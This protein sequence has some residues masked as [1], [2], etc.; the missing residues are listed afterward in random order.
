VQKRDL[1][2]GGPPL[3]VL[4]L[5]CNNFGRTTDADGAAEV[6]R[7]A[8]DEGITHFDTAEMYGEGRSEEFLGAAL[9]KHRHDVVIATKFTPRR[10]AEFRPGDL[11]ARIREAAEQS[12]R[13]LGTDWIDLYYQHYPDPQAP[14][15]ELFDAFEKLVASGKVL[16]VAVSNVDAD[17]LSATVDASTTR[18]GVSLRA[19]QIELNLLARA[20]KRTVLPVAAAAGLGVIPYFPLASGLLTGKYSG[21][22]FPRGSRLA[23]DPYFAQVASEANLAAVRRLTRLAKRYDRTLVE[24][25]FGWLFAHDDVTSV[26]AG[27]TSAAQVRANAAAVGWWL[28]DTE[29][30]EI[31]EALV[32]P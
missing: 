22:S 27:A 10:S 30:A 14:S 11:A 18:P 9:G 32:E 4:G 8:L 16:S 25:A 28:G 3:S 21:G 26:I 6:V 29:L 20:A 12:L 7:V 2:T 19:V 13:R 31:D 5:G 17:G 23:T 15:D 24:L 1:G